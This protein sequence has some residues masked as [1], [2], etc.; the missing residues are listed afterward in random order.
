MTTGLAVWSVLV[1]G[2]AAVG[3]GTLSRVPLAVLTLTALAAFEAVTGLPAAAMQLGQA[4]T[5]ARRICAV[6]DTPDPLREPAAPRPLPAQL[7][8]ARAVALALRGASVRYRPDGPLALAD[9]DLDLPPGRRVALVG[10]NGAGK[11]TVAAVLLR[12]C[13]LA[14]GTATMCG[15]DL[16]S[17]DADEVR[18][19]VGGCPQDPHIFNNTVGANLRLAKPGASDDEVTD[20]AARARLL[21]WISSLPQ[22][23]E[24]RVGAHGAAIS[25]GERQRLALA[26]ALLA[27]PAVLILD[28]PTASLEL[29]SRRSLMADLLAVT[30]G[31]STLLITH[32]LEGLEQMDEIVVL[33]RGRTVE[34]GPHRDLVRAGGLYRQMWEA[35]AGQAVS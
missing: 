34:R 21:P 8:S 24:T 4:R 17:F 13:D 10:P 27:D 16:A 12:F 23:L 19:L 26:R 7:S 35:S 29:A 25:G 33:D 5:S 3:S 2:V 20:A 6:I 15:Q 28:E 31:R 14:A 9:F 11:S 30:A 18:R 1:L 32:E 22:G